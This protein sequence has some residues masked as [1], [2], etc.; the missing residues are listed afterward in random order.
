MTLNILIG[1]GGTGAKVVEA[2]LHAAVA[3]LTDNLK[4]GLV[5]QDGSNGNVA[6]ACQL[7]NTICEA[8][9]AW[10]GSGH[11]HVLGRSGLLSADIQPLL[12]DP[13]WTPHPDRSTTLARIFEREA[14]PP[15][16]RALFDALFA[17]GAGPDDT[18]QNLPLGKGYRGRPHI[19]AAAMASRIED[20]IPFWARLTDLLD[21]ARGGTEVRI[22]LAG[23]VFGGTGAAG[24]PTLARLIRERLPNG[25]TSKVTIGGVLMLP[26]FD[27][28]PPSKESVAADSLNDNVARSDDLVLQSK[29]ALKSYHDIIAQKTFN[30]L[31]FVGWDQF[32]DL[33]YHEAGDTDQ[34]NL[35]LLPEWMGALAACRF[36]NGDAASAPGQALVSARHETGAVEW[37]DL[38]SPSD[39]P[40]AAF[41]AMGGLLRFSVAWKHWGDKVSR[42][43]AG[44]ILG[45][46][47]E[48]WYKRQRVDQIRYAQTPV[49][50]GVKALDAYADRLISWAAAIE[51]H[52]RSANLRFRPW[53][54]EPF[55][56]PGSHPNQPMKAPE[57]LG[58]GAFVKAYD[59]VVGL[60]DQAETLP[61]AAA[62]IHRLT[63]EVEPDHGQRGLGIFVSALHAFSAIPA[64]QSTGAR[65]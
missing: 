64:T 53:N 1:I 65:A 16:E 61:N 7:L 3:G 49:E 54:T 21:T 42:P 4:V 37:R 40:D 52:A 30:Q 38:P 27:F 34:I 24:F 6:R 12:K 31:Y 29:S 11:H 32:F 46:G 18:E 5:D 45:L 25:A 2:T 10:R 62:L 36:F 35:S 19:G 63:Y 56:L 39:D 55:V 20:D 9:T 28:D 58:D 43:R 23:S 8:R 44:R 17:V 14:M 50:A 13:I 60:A 41:K 59:S 22:L 26:Y 33:G 51:M 48:P 57:T 47:S 15:P